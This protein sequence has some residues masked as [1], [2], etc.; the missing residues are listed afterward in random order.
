MWSN[1]RLFNPRPL[2]LA[3]LTFAISLFILTITCTHTLLSLSSA[4]FLA[5]LGNQNHHSIPH[6]LQQLQNSFK[7]KKPRY[8]QHVYHRT[9]PPEHEKL[10]SNDA[11]MP[12]E[13]NVRSEETDSSQ[14]NMDFSMH[15]ERS[16]AYR[17]DL[18]EDGEIDYSGDD[19]L[20]DWESDFYGSEEEN[21][22]YDSEDE[23]ERYNSEEDHERYDSEQGHERYDS[24]QEHE[25][26]DSADTHDEYGDYMTEEDL[27][28]WED[29]RPRDADGGWY[30]SNLQGEDD[31][32]QSDNGVDDNSWDGE[33]LEEDKDWEEV[34]DWDD[35]I[36]SVGELE[37]QD[38]ENTADWADGDF[39][40]EVAESVADSDKNSDYIEKLSTLGRRKKGPVIYGLEKYVVSDNTVS[41]ADI[42]MHLG[43]HHFVVE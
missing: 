32:W 20:D 31:E 41:L 39:L 38:W 18:N 12:T 7:P 21:V 40:R 27:S 37:D 2:A 23:Q 42:Q 8:A 26:Y 17:G 33:S 9:F 30:D 35:E 36:A 4:S 11:T 43:P 24:E 5:L 34:T 14:P 25:R 29:D 3:G 16:Y 1:T 15:E 22:R 28:D 19:E 10:E 6:S 13:E